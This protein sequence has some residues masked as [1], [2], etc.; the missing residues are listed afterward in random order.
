MGVIERE[1][2]IFDGSELFFFYA[3]RLFKLDLLEINIRLF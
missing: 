2:D 3:G 1:G